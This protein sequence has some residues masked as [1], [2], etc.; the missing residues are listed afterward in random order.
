[1]SMFLG[2]GLDRVESQSEIL[3]RIMGSRSVQ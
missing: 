2:C 1:M 3:M